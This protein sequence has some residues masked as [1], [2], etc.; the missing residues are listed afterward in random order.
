MQRSLVH[1]AVSNR[2]ITLK[3]STREAVGLLRELLNHIFSKIW[4]SMS[5]SETR[6][7]CSC[8]PPVG[9]STPRGRVTFLQNAWHCS[10]SIAVVDVMLDRILCWRKGGSVEQARGEEVLG[11]GE[12]RGCCIQ[13]TQSPPSRKNAAGVYVSGQF[14]PLRAMA[15]ARWNQ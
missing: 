15:G 5:V 6:S 3:D 1:S 11:A 4:K 14:R 2:A 12:A 10:L 7:S 13:T 9:P 8:S